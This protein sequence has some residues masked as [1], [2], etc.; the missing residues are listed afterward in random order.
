M[1]SPHWPFGT[2]RGAIE[3]FLRSMVP[4]RANQIIN[5]G[6]GVR[7]YPPY[8]EGGPPR[9]VQRGKNGEICCSGLGC[10]NAIDGCIHA[11]EDEFRFGDLSAG[12]WVPPIRLL[13]V[14]AKRDGAAYESVER[15]L[16]RPNPTIGNLKTETL[17]RHALEA[18]PVEFIEILANTVRVL[19]R[20]EQYKKRVNGISR[21]RGRPEVDIWDL[22][23]MAVLRIHDGLS[24]EELQARID[25]YSREGD[26]RGPFLTAR[27]C[28]ARVLEAM[29]GITKSDDLNQM[30]KAEIRMTAS[31][32]TLRD[33]LLPI[34][35]HV[36][37]VVMCDGMTLSTA[38]T[39]NARKGH[40]S[41]TKSHQVTLHAMYEHRWG[42][43]VAYRLTWHQRGRGSAEVI[44]FPYLLRTTKERFPE[45]NVILGDMAFGSARNRALALVAGVDFYCGIKESQFEG[46]SAE[47]WLTPE[48]IEA[49][50]ARNSAENPLFRQV[51]PF[52][53]RV[54]GW[55]EVQRSQ[56]S[57]NLISKVDS[58]RRPATRYEKTKENPLRAD[59]ELPEDQDEREH[60]IET[61][62]FVGRACHNE[63]LCRQIMSIVRA[64]VK[65]QLW[66]ETRIDLAFPR[67]FRPRPEDAEFSIFRPRINQDAV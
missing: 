4:E 41:R 40:I 19:R 59:L 35:Q 1:A 13:R 48:Q 32:T 11:W 26:D 67:P 37:T 33:Y 9:L 34:F 52:R 6:N 17:M 10:E 18:M 60:I 47:Q 31:L 30:A 63:M 22:V 16:P 45:V 65:A 61:E 38:A 53:N 46:K 21:E 55:I 54:E 62:Q 12:N 50:K 8:T 66:Y 57:R 58:S 25:R 43:V 7:L 28:H 27:F 15:Y 42:I 36:T 39:D 5:Y 23:I 29:T 49:E 51:Y 24:Y 2:S 20:K 3:G 56:A 64:I 44:Q 14:S